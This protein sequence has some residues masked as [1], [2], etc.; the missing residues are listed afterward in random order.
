MKTTKRRGRSAF[1]L[2]ELLIV[3]AI[4][5][6]LLLLSAGAAVRMMG[7]AATS[8]TRTTIDKAGLAFGGQASYLRDRGQQDSIPANIITL[9][10]GDQDRARVIYIKLR[11][12][13]A[14][15]QSF[16]EALYPG[17]DPVTS[18]DYIQP[19]PSYVTYLRNK[20]ITRASYNP[21]L[22]V[23]APAAHESAACLY[24]SL[25]NG[26][27]AV[28]EDQLG[29]AGSVVTIDG[30]PCLADA[31]QQPLLFCRW[32][33]GDH[34]G[35]YASPA[36]NPTGISVVNPD[37]Y[38]A[39]FKDP[40]DP[41][42]TLNDASWQNSSNGQVFQRVCH[43]LYPRANNTV[44]AATLDLSAAIMSGGPDRKPGVNLL[45]F[46]S[47]GADSNDNIIKGRLR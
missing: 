19:L 32:P 8:A 14:F 28:S 7:G 47:T 10:G 9:A 29:L 26:P 37:G 13:Q 45:T 22:G 43:L 34:S 25:R 44:Q 17:Y 21:A 15:P 39:G 2:V 41:R 27:E 31:F 40:G 23:P 33:I 5:T 18:I 36:T 16:F 12:K 3:I 46:A 42:G 24:M 6:L 38:V 4:I 35:L 1:T 20:G 30:F 11:M